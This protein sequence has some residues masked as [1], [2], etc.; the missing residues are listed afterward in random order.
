MAKRETLV[1]FGLV[2]LCL[3]AVVPVYQQ[4]VKAQYSVDITID[5]NGIIDPLT[6]PIS[7]M[8]NLFTLTDN[9]NGAITVGSSNI[10]LDGNHFTLSGGLTLKNI[11]NVTVTDFNIVGGVDPHNTFIGVYG[12][13]L[14]SDTRIHVENNSISG[15]WNIQALSGVSYTGLNVKG[16]SFNVISGNTF[17]NNLRGLGFFNTFNNLIERNTITCETNPSQLY[18]SVGGIYFANA[19]NNTIYHNN[20][21]VTTINSQAGNYDSINVWDD[22]YPSGGNYWIDYRSKYPHIQTIDNSGIGN[23]TYAIDSRNKDN[24]PLISPF[25]FNLYLARTTKPEIRALSAENQTYSSNNVL[26][27]FTVDKATSWIGYSF[28]EQQNVTVIGN[29][30]IANMTNGMHSIA[31]YANDTFGNM[32]V[33]TSNFNVNQ[34][35]STAKTYQITVQ[36]LILI[37]TVAVIAV[38]VASLLL[39]RRH[40]K[41][42][43]A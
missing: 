37:A 40:R 36:T 23:V 21:N 33:Q 17:L 29:F 30:T 1:G 42:A 28:D 27:N 6:A 24:Y 18:D 41:T 19:S 4:S 38:I 35:N 31:I 15:I 9:I 39:Y 16:G 22:G 2:L 26:F 3:I 20:F 8:D 32:G 13:L 5:A 34:L 11:S 14:D 25:D 43:K 7:K 12:I 10:I